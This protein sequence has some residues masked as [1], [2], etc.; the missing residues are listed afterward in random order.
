MATRKNCLSCH[1]VGVKCQLV[2]DGTPCV[3][4]IKNHLPCVFLPALRAG[5]CHPLPQ[6]PLP[7]PPT[8]PQW[9]HKFSA[10]TNSSNR[11]K[12]AAVAF[13]ANAS[14]DF[15]SKSRLSDR[16]KKKEVKQD[17]FLKLVDGILEC[18][19]W[20]TAEDIKKD[21]VVFDGTASFPAPPIIPPQCE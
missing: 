16:T 14:D 6:T 15:I 21:V 13:L 7:P 1:N 4:C 8:I 3:R 18:T 17:K 10:N 5:M 9:T 19:S 20:L 11:V 2:G 12:A